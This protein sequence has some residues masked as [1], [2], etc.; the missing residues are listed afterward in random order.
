MAGALAATRYQRLYDS[1]VLRAL[2]ATRALVAR[3]FAVE[4][5][6]LGAAAGL[7]GSAL[8]ILLAWVVLR[9]VLEVPWTFEPLPIL[10]GIALTTAVALA[11]GFLATFRLLG[12]R[13]LSVLR[14]E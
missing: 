14:R 7:G 10:L 11:V 8:A 2:G 13:P 6:C 9:F 12:A 1:V 5:A 3:A 4:Y